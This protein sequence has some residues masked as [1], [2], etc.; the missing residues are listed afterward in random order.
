MTS[1]LGSLNPVRPTKI[2][3]A[4]TYLHNTCSVAES[5]TEQDIGIGEEPFLQ[6]DD[7]LFARESK[8]AR[9]ST[10]TYKLRPLESILEELSD[11]LS[12]RQIQSSVYLI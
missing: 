7:D 4:A 6:T 12:M 3:R 10:A 1:S 9:S 5:G 11:V 2:P 8:E